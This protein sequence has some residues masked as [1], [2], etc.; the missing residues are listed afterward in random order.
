MNIIDI[1]SS[2]R[3]KEHPVIKINNTPKMFI[4]QQ[5]V[6][7]F[8]T[9]GIVHKGTK[10]ILFPIAKLPEGPCINTIVVYKNRPYNSSVRGGIKFPP[11]SIKF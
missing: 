6:I 8:L 4:F 3:L 1:N 5:F 9:Y 11:G 7:Y 10:T 2:C